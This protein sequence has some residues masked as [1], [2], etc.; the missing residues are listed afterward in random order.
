MKIAL[1]HDQLHEFGGAERVFLNLKKIFPEADVFTAYHTPS[2][3]D[4]FAPDWKSWK[5]ISSWVQKIPF[6]SRLASPLRFLDPW[7]WESFD[8]SAYDLVISSSGG[9]MCKGI[10]TRPET[11]HISYIH[12][13]PRYLYYYQTAMN[14]QRFLPVKIYGYLINHFLRLWDYVG[15]QRPNFLIANSEETKRRIKKFY[16]RD[17]TVIYPPVQISKEM[18]SF[19][20]K[21]KTY[22]VTLSRLVGSKHIDLLIEAAKKEKFKLQIIGTGKDEEY[23]KTIADEHIEFLGRVEDDKLYDIYSKAKAFLNGAVDEEFGIAQIEAMSYGLP[24]IAFA[25]GG[26]LETVKDGVNGYLFDELSVGSLLLAIDKLERLPKDEYLKICKN[27]QVE[28]EKYSEDKFAASIN[29]FVTSHARVTRSRI[30]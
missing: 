5:L 10:I 15:S 25:S 28:A 17:A 20:P 26:H 7:I 21:P 22:Y 9:H 12:H 16:R 8:L 3:L 13:Q 6:I 11:M 18:L 4:K 30:D 27:S 14:W 1:V 2:Q 24:V 19:N 29:K 23:L